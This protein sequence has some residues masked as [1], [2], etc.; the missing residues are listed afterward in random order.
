M[1]TNII[2]SKLEEETETNFIEEIE[3]EAALLQNM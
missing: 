3:V 1:S 2:V